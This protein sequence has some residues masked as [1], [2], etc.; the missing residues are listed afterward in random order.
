MRPASDARS[1]YELHLIHPDTTERHTQQLK[2]LL[3]DFVLGLTLG[4]PGNVF[5]K[6]TLEIVDIRTNRTVLKID[7]RVEDAQG[8]VDLIN[9]DLD[10]LDPPTFAVRDAPFAGE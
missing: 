3:A 1:V 2:N 5:V 7:Q 9:S 8:L 4:S 10:R 6:V